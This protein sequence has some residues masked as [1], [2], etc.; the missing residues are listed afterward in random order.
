[1][2]GPPAASAKCSLISAKLEAEHSSGRP[3]ISR[4]IALPCFD[5]PT[6]W[7][8]LATER[9]VG[10]AVPASC[11]QQNMQLM[12]RGIRSRY[13]TQLQFEIISPRAVFRRFRDLHLAK[14]RFQTLR[15]R[16]IRLLVANCQC[17]IAQL[18]VLFRRMG[19][20]HCTISS[21]RNKF[22]HALKVI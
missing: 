15:T 4:S 5:Q 1:M 10:A 14:T 21:P 20:I 19:R 11:F 7:R 18:G 13:Q 17:R 3:E 9:G 22:S 12:L 6:A 16:K 2:V 8:S